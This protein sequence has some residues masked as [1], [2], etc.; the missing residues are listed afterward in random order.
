M[1][2][3]IKGIQDLNIELEATTEGIACNM[4][5]PIDLPKM[6]DVKVA[7]IDMSI[8]Q[9]ELKGVVLDGGSGVNSITK[10]IA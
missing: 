1:K 8:N 2:V 3:F 5:Q 9:K 4:A 7:T 6:W 10:D